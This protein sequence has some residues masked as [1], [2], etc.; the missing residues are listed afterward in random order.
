[1]EQVLSGGGAGLALI[2]ASNNSQVDSELIDE[3]I[4]ST[5]NLLNHQKGLA[6]FPSL[7]KIPCHV[8]DLTDNPS[9]QTDTQER[10]IHLGHVNSFAEVPRSVLQVLCKDF[11]IKA[12]MTNNEMRQALSLRAQ[13]DNHVIVAL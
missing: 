9:F 7:L 1:L 3:P 8:S 13:S 5:G 12:N 11:N 10:A 4:M 2:D 6:D